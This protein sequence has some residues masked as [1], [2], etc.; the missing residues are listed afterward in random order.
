MRLAQLFH[1]D[2]TPIND[3]IDKADKTKNAHPADRSQYDI[4]RITGQHG[5]HYL[6]LR[7]HLAGKRIVHLISDLRR[8]LPR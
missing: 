3:A 5:E 4:D 6:R 7:R 1:H 2:G 8:L